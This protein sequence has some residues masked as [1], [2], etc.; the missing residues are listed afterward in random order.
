MNGSAGEVSNRKLGDDPATGLEIS[1]RSGRFGPYLQLGEGKDGEK[2]KR[3]SLP[4]GVAPDEMDLAR[5]I[6]LLSLP[7]EV[8]IHPEDG[9]PIKAGIGRYGPYVQHGKTYANLEDGDEVFH[10]GLNRAVTLI[11]EKSAKPSKGRRFGADPGRALG[12]HPTK[13][14]PVV[15]K[16][17]RYGPYVSHNGVNAT[18]P[19]DKTPENVTLEEAVA[20]IDARAGSSPAPHARP[21]KAK[22][23]SPG[24][25]RV[26]K[27][28]SKRP[29]ARAGKR[30]PKAT[31]A[32]E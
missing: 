5:A 23:P 21:R 27:A 4:K 19:A 12:D 22:R 8:G 20:L 6:A 2:P 25:A 1:V 7:R 9:E 29:G 18:L 32:A 10:I 31:Q 24:T 13:G 28:P 3:A 14:G 30:P 11:A 16:N 15:A 26:V 17:G